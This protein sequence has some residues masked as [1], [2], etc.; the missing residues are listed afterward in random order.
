M[1]TP[2]LKALF[3]TPTPNQLIARQVDAGYVLV[4]LAHEQEQILQAQRGGD[5]IF[6]KLDNLAKYAHSLGAKNFEVQLMP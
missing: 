5:R 4:L 1:K 2:I 6:K 3:L